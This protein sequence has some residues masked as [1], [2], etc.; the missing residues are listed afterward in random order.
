[1]IKTLQ[2]LFLK[3]N[4]SAINR[5]LILNRHF[6]NT[7]ILKNSQENIKNEIEKLVKNDSVV[8]FMKGT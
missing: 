7:V 4:L 5:T 1:M 8:V 2:N 3:P 6:S